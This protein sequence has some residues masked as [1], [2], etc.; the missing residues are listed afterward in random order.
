VEWRLLREYISARIAVSLRGMS[1]PFLEAA[2]DHYPRAKGSSAATS[3]VEDGVPR[4]D[5][6]LGWLR[7]WASWFG[8]IGADQFYLRSPMTGLMKAITLGGFGL[9]WLWDAVQVYAEGDRV[10]K[11]GMSA[12]FDFVTGIGQGM[13]YDGRMS[14][15]SQKNDFSFW[16]LGVVFSFM[17]L[18]SLISGANGRFFRQILELVLFILSVW[19]ASHFRFSL[20]WV[21]AILFTVFFGLMIGT[22]YLI[23]LRKLMKEPRVL[24]TE[25][26]VVDGK[27]QKDLNYYVQGLLNWIPVTD[28]QRKEMA[29]HLN[30]GS[31]PPDILRKMF[32]IV[33][34]SEQFPDSASSSSSSSAMSPIGAF[35]W[36]VSSP[37]WIILLGIYWLGVKIYDALL[38]FFPAAKVLINSAETINSV[39]KSAGK[40]ASGVF[41]A[42]AQEVKKHPADAVKAALTRQSGGAKIP[43]L[44]NESV[45][46]G[47]VIAALA[48]GGALKAVIDYLMPQ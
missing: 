14:K 35:L 8:W 17:G 43:A 36:W 45:I 15:Y 42:L 9:W 29:G 21:A 11:Y 7:F 40:E 30:Y 46:A 32:E 19:S 48:G 12:P 1:D 41:S 34:A 28:E 44:S 33:H 37:I 3:W 25:G 20:G 18:D 6:N 31:V 22:E 39:V 23:S 4:P 10:L 13:I 24:M 16:S 27:T 26:M 2:Q 38:S 5:K 47:V